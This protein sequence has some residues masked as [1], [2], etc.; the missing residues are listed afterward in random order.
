MTASSPVHT[1][2]RPSY[3]SSERMWHEKHTGL[4]NLMVSRKVFAFCH[5][6][7]MLVFEMMVV[8]VPLL[9]WSAGG[10]KN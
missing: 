9:V 3:L 5:H 4:V 1:M 6:R 10:K 7:L 2:L 8:I